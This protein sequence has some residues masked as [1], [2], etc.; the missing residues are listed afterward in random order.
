MGKHR[1]MP[2]GGAKKPDGKGRANWTGRQTDGGQREL[3]AWLRLALGREPAAGAV[4][5]RRGRLGVHRGDWGFAL[6]TTSFQTREE[7]AL[8][9]GDHS[10][11]DSERMRMERGGRGVGRQQKGMGGAARGGEGRGEEQRWGRGERHGTHGNQ[12]RVK[13]TNTDRP[14]ET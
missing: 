8:E 11:K 5:S 10:E 9:E 12:K 13:R 2:G 1:P 3:G 4:G 6:G 7:R 14:Q